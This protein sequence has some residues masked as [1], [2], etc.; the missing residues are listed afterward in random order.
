MNEKQIERTR[1][2]L[3]WIVETFPGEWKLSTA[4]GIEG[5]VLIDLL[6]KI[7]RNPRIFTIDTGRLPQA[8]YDLMEQ[9]RR[10]Y[11]I[12]IEVFFPDSRSLEDLVILHGVNL[13]YDSQEKR[14]L[15]C[16]VRKVEP[17]Q[18]ALSGVSIWMSGLRREQSQYRSRRKMFEHDD[19]GRIKAFP[20][21]EWTTQE[22]WGY[23]ER[24]Q[25][26]YNRLYD[27]GYTSIG[28]APCSRPS[29][30]HGDLRAGRWWWE[31]G[32]KKECGLHG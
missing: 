11:G 32:G 16:G 5:M 6:C 21:F 13:F 17:L 19:Q 10:H 22:V 27:E 23:I 25:L 12:S 8:T 24:Y 18:R 31:A 1:K 28:C 4:F 26:P 7:T 14:R 3:H 15:C 2:V 30:L 29:E 20:L 9:V